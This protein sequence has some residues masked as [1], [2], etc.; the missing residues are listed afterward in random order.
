[1]QVTLLGVPQYLAVHAD[2]LVV[3]DGRQERRLRPR[4]LVRIYELPHFVL[5]MSRNGSELAIPKP[6]FASGS[7]ARRF[8]R[9]LASV[10]GFEPD[11]GFRSEWM[12]RSPHAGSQG[13]VFGIAVLCLIAV[14]CLLVALGLVLP[15]IFRAFE[16]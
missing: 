5:L 12:G 10:A 16:P 8:A 11:L 4:E 14:I 15:T 2:G 13:R 9:A 6:A 1:M 3:F 7:R